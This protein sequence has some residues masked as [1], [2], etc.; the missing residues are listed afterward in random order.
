MLVFYKRA[1]ETILFGF[2]KFWFFGRRKFNADPAQH[3]LAQ[4]IIEVVDIR[5]ERRRD[6]N[7]VLGFLRSLGGSRSDQSDRLI[8]AGLM[9]R[10]W[11][12]DL[13]PL[14]RYLCIDISH[15]L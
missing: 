4:L 1:G 8:H 14:A 6:F 11:R 7:D 10:D 3:Q 12:P 9:V 5:Q 13:Y 15:M 2:L